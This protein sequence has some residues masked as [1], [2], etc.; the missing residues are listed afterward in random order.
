MNHFVKGKK[1]NYTQ[2]LSALTSQHPE[3]VEAFKVKMAAWLPKKPIKIGATII[4]P[5][6]QTMFPPDEEALL[7]EQ[8][9]KRQKRSYI[10]FIVLIKE[11]KNCVSLSC[12]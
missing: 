9:K 4:Q 6:T 12:S 2:I 8:Y 1:L 5:T 7:K 11:K 3:A 10:S